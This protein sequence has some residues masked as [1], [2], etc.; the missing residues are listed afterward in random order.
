M[1]AIFEWLLGLKAGELAGTDWSFGLIAV[2]NQYVKLLM[3]LVFV[4]MVWLTVR[5]YRREGE[6][7]GRAKG[8]LAALRI[9]I[10]LL[11][12]L[13]LFQPAIVLHF[14][15][16]LFKSVAVVLDDSLSMSRPDRYAD[17]DVA[18]AKEATAAMLGVSQEELE[19]ISRAEI[20]RR[21]LLR[22][23]GAMTRLANDHPL[24]A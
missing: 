22:P 5:C 8:F 15:D 2:Y 23:D 18:A 7:S 6:A 19:K 3:L 14:R 24:P 17:R 12:F 16:T 1:N 21:A 20:V 9:L 4:A 11:I 10:I 13:V